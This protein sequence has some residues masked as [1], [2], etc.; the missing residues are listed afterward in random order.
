MSASGQLSG[1]T[2]TGAHRAE[3]ACSLTPLL[4]SIKE[5]AIESANS[6]S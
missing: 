2:G 4:P 3:N 6:Q 1:N 5:G